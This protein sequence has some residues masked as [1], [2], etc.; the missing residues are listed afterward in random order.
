MERNRQK[1]QLL[2]HEYGKRTKRQANSKEKIEKGVQRRW[3]KKKGVTDQFSSGNGGK[4]SDGRIERRNQ[5]NADCRE[6][7]SL[8][9]VGDKR[10]GRQSTRAAQ[11]GRKR[12]YR[13]HEPQKHVLKTKQGK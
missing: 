5:K 13:P 2:G 1:D 4:T 10:G 7:E 8:I 3:V 11:G 6:G 12:E 9:H